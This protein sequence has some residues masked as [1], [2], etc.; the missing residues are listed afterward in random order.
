MD[1]DWHRGE[2]TEPT[3]EELWPQV[4]DSPIAN[5]LTSTSGAGMAGGG[6]ASMG[7]GRGG[8]GG[9]ARVVTA[10]PELMDKLAT[11]PAATEQPT[12]TIP[13]SLRAMFASV[14]WLIVAVTALLVIGVVADLAFPTLVRFAV[15]RGIQAGSP[16]TLWQVAGAALVVVLVAWAANA[17]MTVLSSRSGER[18][19]YGL[20]VRLSLIHI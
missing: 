19:L 5:H 13:D 17:A 4:D 3:H 12:G 6:M 14:K 9:T 7:G 2:T 18:L 10:T 8:G 16:S 15:D 11:L 20:R 1:P